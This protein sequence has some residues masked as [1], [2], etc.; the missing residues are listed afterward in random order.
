M[1]QGTSPMSNAMPFFSST[2]G[3]KNYT[4]KMQ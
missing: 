4:M 1:R 2:V 3:V